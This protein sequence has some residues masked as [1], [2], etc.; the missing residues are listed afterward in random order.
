MTDKSTEQATA[1]EAK[2]PVELLVMPDDL[3]MRAYYYG[4]DKTGVREIDEILSAVAMA[5]KGYHHTENWSDELYSE[6]YSYIDL[7][8]EM[9]NR[10][11]RKLKPV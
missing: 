10:A 5:G 7:I 2:R 4:F 8:Q 3:P 9:A 6:P 1:E 11:A